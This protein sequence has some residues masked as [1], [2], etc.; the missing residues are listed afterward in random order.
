MFAV[1]HE[2]GSNKRLVGILVPAYVLTNPPCAQFAQMT[3]TPTQLLGNA[4]A[5]TCRLYE[6]DGA[7]PVH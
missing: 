3:A 7:S 5:A 2:N 1:S 4:G 6:A